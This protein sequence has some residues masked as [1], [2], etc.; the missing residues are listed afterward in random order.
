MTALS[1]EVATNRSLEV[2][3]VLKVFVTKQFQRFVEFRYTSNGNSE[4]WRGS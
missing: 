3:K 2:A 4:C 1:I